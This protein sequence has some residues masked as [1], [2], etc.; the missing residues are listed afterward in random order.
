MLATEINDFILY[1]NSLYE[2]HQFWL[3]FLYIAVKSNRSDSENDKCAAEWKR[4]CKRQQQ[5]KFEENEK[6]SKTKTKQN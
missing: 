2:N 1:L 3:T 4:V 5:V 6:K